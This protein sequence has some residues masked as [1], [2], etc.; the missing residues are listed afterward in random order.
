MAYTIVDP[1]LGMQPIAVTDTTMNHPL[2]KRIGLVGET[3]PFLCIDGAPQV[4]DPSTSLFNI[5]VVRLGST[6]IAKALGK[7]DHHGRHFILPIF[8]A[9]QRCAEE[10]RNEDKNHSNRDSGRHQDS[11][12]NPDDD[13]SD[14]DH[15]KDE[16]QQRN[17]EQ[18]NSAVGSAHVIADG[19]MNGQ[20]HAAC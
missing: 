17:G 4:A 7:Y 8:G 9:K 10:K 12:W 16:K 18:E 6:C 19:V 14:D 3:P 20:R 5:R 15:R 11:P 2:G 1:V 13:S